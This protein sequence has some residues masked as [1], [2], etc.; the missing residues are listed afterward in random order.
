M[1]DYK[2]F[3]EALHTAGNGS[4]YYLICGCKLGVGAPDPRRGWETCPA[5]ASRA[6][7]TPRGA[8]V[9]GLQLGSWGRGAWNLV[10]NH[11]TRDGEPAGARRGLRGRH[12]RAPR[13]PAP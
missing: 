9:R 10:F 7:S 12:R 4:I 3:G 8:M 11:I 6:G 1:A 13:E 5:E 2:K